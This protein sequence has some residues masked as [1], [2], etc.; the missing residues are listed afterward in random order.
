MS[1]AHHQKGESDQEKRLD[2]L[3]SLLKEPDTNSENF[4]RIKEDILSQRV[5][6]DDKESNNSGVKDTI[7]HVH[8]FL[9]AAKVCLM[10]KFSLN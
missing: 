7:Q 2:R 4:Q 1:T 9:L 3:I 6:T 10:S 8:D 5:F